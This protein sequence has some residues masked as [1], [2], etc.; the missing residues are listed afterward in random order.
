M[1]R[2]R[3]CSRVRAGE[4]RNAGGRQR[5]RAREDGDRQLHLRADLLGKTRIQLVS[6]QDERASL[7]GNRRPTAEQQRQLP[8]LRIQKLP[9]GDGLRAF[10]RLDVCPGQRGTAGGEYL[11]GQQHGAAIELAGTAILVEIGGERGAVARIE[12]MFEGGAF[13]KHLRGDSQVI[14]AA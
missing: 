8:W 2:W 14:A 7:A 4:A 11:T 1:P 12:V 9:T 3:G 5:R 10:L 6:R 13:G